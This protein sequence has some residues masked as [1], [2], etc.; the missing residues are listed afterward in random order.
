MGSELLF[1]YYFFIIFLLFLLF[2]S[3]CLAYTWWKTWLSCGLVTSVY[4]FKAARGVS[5]VGWGSLFFFKFF[6]TLYCLA[7]YRFAPRRIVRCILFAVV[8]CG[9]LLAVWEGVA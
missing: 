1:Y 8:P 2:L 3:A 4:L 9:G 7:T 6:F 5:G